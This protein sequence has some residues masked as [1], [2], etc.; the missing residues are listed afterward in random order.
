MNAK[1]GVVKGVAHMFPMTQ[2]PFY[3]FLTVPL[4][5]SMLP[6]DAI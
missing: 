4:L 1:M 5:F 3:S 2:S 6:L